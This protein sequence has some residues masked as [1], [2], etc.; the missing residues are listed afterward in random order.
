MGGF[1]AHV[2][3]ALAQAGLLDRGLRIRTLTLPDRIIEHDTQ[4]RQYAEAGL[5]AP[6]IVAAALEALGKADD[7]SG[8]ARA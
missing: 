1:G 5:D 3:H 8:R 7:V 2:L 6:A 4:A